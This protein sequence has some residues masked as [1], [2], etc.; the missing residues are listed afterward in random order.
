MTTHINNG[1]GRPTAMYMQE[2]QP[3]HSVHQV[4]TQKKRPVENNISW[5]S[6]H[7]QTDYRTSTSRWA[8]WCFRLTVQGQD[9]KNP[10]L[11]SQ[12]DRQWSIGNPLAFGNPVSLHTKSWQFNTVTAHHFHLFLK[13]CQNHPFFCVVESKTLL[14]KASLEIVQR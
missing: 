1:N 6:F 5:L 10:P 13:R 9:E 12:L 4:L 3:T 7:S 8:H 11:K 14:Q 2:T